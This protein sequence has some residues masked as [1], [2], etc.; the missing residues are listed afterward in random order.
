MTDGINRRGHGQASGKGHCWFDA[1]GNGA[2]WADGR[3]RTKWIPQNQ[4][5]RQSNGLADGGAG[6]RTEENRSIHDDAF[7]HTVILEKHRAIC[8]KCRRKAQ[9]SQR[10]RICLDCNEVVPG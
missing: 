4:I 8:P 3:Q 6:E 1:T 9:K 5:M 2:G 10:G 7:Y